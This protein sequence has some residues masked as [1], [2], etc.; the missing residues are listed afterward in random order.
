MTILNATNRNSSIVSLQSSPNVSTDNNM[1]VL[2]A[3]NPPVLPANNSS[4]L[5]KEITNIIASYLDTS[6]LERQVER[7]VVLLKEHIGRFHSILH[8][9]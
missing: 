4:R 9:M 6:D 7:Q 5:P 1:A 8:Q 3:N 2:P